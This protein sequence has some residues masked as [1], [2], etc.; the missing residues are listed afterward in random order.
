MAILVHAPPLTPL[1]PFTSDA[2]DL[3]AFEPLVK[4]YYHAKFWASSSKIDRVMAILVHDPPP[5]PLNP[6]P[7]MLLTSV[8]L[9]A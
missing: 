3:S 4:N 1:N 8:Y 2:P 7:L 5:T 9:S 6:P